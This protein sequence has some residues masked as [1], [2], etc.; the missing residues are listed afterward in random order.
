[1]PVKERTAKARRP[2]FSAEA[3]ELF[4]RLEGMKARNSKTFKD[5]EHELARKLDLVSEFWTCNSVLDRSREPCHPPGCIAYN[6]W[7]TCRRVRLALL[8]ATS[9]SP[10]VRGNG[11]THPVPAA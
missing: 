7:F 9:P 8:A 4:V 6:N 3:L 1:M 5:G 2:Q 10:R 11:R